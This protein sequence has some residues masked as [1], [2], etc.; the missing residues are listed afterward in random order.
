MG[1][2]ASVPRSVSCHAGAPVSPGG[3]AIEGRVSTG[4]GRGCDLLDPLQQIG[5]AGGGCTPGR[6][7]SSH[8]GW[9]P[10]RRRHAS[11]PGPPPFCSL[12]KLIGTLTIGWPLY[13]FF[14]VSSHP[15]EQKWVNH[16]DPWSPIFRWGPAESAQA[17]RSA[18]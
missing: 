8:P 10:P 3:A 15:Y 7:A 2:G 17:Q 5:P 14:N 11:R 16:F 6:C 4:Q 13:L 18:S 9:L 12:V 1:A